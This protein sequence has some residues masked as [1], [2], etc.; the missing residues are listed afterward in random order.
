MFRLALSAFVVFLLIVFGL[1][2]ASFYVGRTTGEHVVT[3]TAA[4][5]SLLNTKVYVKTSRESSQEEAYCIRDRNISRDLYLKLQA[6]ARVQDTI[7]LGFTQEYEW[8]PWFCRDRIW[9]VE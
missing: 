7:T 4:E 2:V 3:I 9:I 8:L 1:D 5:Q 6:H